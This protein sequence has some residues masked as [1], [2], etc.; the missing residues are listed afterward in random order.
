MFDGAGV[1]V[2]V[3]VHVCELVCVRERANARESMRSE[4]SV[5]V[6]EFF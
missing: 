1:C 4:E 5:F 2:F 3:C 6:Y